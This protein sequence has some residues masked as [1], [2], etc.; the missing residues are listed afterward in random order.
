MPAV[1]KESFSKCGIGTLSLVHP[2]K[3]RKAV[4]ILAMY[5]LLSATG[6]KDETCILTRWNSER[7]SRKKEI[8]WD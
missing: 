5:L 3:A 6:G 8:G 1:L 2:F 4:R 7:G